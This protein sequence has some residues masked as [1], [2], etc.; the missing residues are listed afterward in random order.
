[1]EIFYMKNKKYIYQ[2]IILIFK[3]IKY[4]QMNCFGFNQTN[5]FNESNFFNPYKV[6]TANYMFLF[7]EEDNLKNEINSFSDFKSTEEMSSKGGSNLSVIAE[8]NAPLC[9]EITQITSYEDDL[10]S[11]AL[12]IQS[13]IN[14]GSIENIVDEALDNVFDGTIEKFR[15]IQH[16]KK[17][18]S[19][20]NQY[21]E[22]A[23]EANH[24]WDKAFMQD[25]AGKLGLKYRQ[26][27]KWY[28]DKIKKRQAKQEKKASKVKHNKFEDIESAF[29]SVFN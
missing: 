14:N 27:Y 4:N 7:N 25:M 5:D 17:K 6:A 26:V 20:Q 10:N 2:L 21:L 18:T 12:D 22:Q 9:E 1:M 29:S 11:L 23:L 28:W 8:D 19:A 15:P 16:K 13:K 3:K 24:E